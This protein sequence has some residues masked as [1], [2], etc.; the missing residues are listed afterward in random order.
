MPTRTKFYT[1]KA[2]SCV[3]SLTNDNAT[4]TGEYIAKL[5]TCITA[6]SNRPIVSQE[7]VV[8]R[9]PSAPSTN[10]APIKITSS[11]A[12]DLGTLNIGNT[13]Y[14]LWFTNKGS[15]QIRMI[16]SSDVYG[17]QAKTP[18]FIVPFNTPGQFT[19]EMTDNGQMVLSRSNGTG[20]RITVPS[21]EYYSSRNIIAENRK[22]TRLRFLPVST[23]GVT[24]PSLVLDNP[25]TGP[26]WSIYDSDNKNWTL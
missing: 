10:T 8:L 7:G 25:L 9:P 11:N 3:K 5:A 20:S 18:E 4:S 19:L 2:L 6:P 12:S 26:I 21:D 23:N 24:V 14:K 22:A 13:V 15:L 17:G 16:A 1:N